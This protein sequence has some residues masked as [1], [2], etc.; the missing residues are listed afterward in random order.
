MT[1]ASE[2]AVFGKVACLRVM[3][4]AA[5]KPLNTGDNV[6]AVSNDQNIFKHF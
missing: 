1:G 5:Y 4:E 3:N 2:D 6:I